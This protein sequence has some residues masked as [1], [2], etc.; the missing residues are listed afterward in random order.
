LTADPPYNAGR[1]V[2]R[3]GTALTAGLSYCVRVRP[4]DVDA[5]RAVFGDYTYMNGDAPAFQWLGSPQGERD[6]E[7]WPD[8]H[9]GYLASG[10]YL[11]PGR[12]ATTP[13]MPLF[14]WKPIVR[15]TPSGDVTYG[16]YFVLVAKDESFHTVVDYVFT[17]LPA[18][19]PRNLTYAD[20]T[21]R[22]YWAVL[23]AEGTDGSFA[24]ANPLVARKSDFQKLSVQPTL[25]APADG[26]VATGAPTFEWEP[27]E[28]ARRY[29]LEISKDESFNTGSLLETVMTNAVAYTSNTTFP[30]DAIV[31]WR[32]RGEDDAQQPM[33]WSVTRTLR[34][35]LPTPLPSPLN[36]TS[37]PFVPTLGWSPVQGAVSYDFR[38]EPITGLA[39][40]SSRGAAAYTPASIGGIGAW[41][42]QVRA[43]FPAPG[44][45]VPGPYTELVSFMRQLPAPTDTT[46]DAGARHVVL[47]WLPGNPG[48]G[49]KEFRVQT[50]SRS[51][52][53]T[54]IDDERTENT[55]YAPLL[56][57]LAYT[58]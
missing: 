54:V 30:S 48:N 45:A 13:R 28:A 58:P 25:V 40:T 44:A 23:P 17:R 41:R 52:F 9:D 3:D 20:E 11:L 34:R 24:A 22:Y 4:R 16:S 36:P 50:S 46:T 8:C 5:T 49:I 15:P 51:D 31:Y 2:T 6:C 29:R 7:P 47:S 26:A 56:T 53:A 14:T 33:T 37:G 18:Y 43:K 1:P 19:A 32:V 12:G 21:T 55:R 27:V 10:S 57:R 39:Q 38:V 42:W 35:L